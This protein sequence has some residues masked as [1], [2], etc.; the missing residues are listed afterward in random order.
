[1]GYRVS[2]DLFSRRLLCFLFR[3]R[4]HF[5]PSISRVIRSGNPVG[6]SVV[7]YDFDLFFFL[8]SGYFPCALLRFRDCS[9]S[10]LYLLA[11][12][13]ESLFPLWVLISDFTVPL[14]GWDLMHC[15]RCL[16]DDQQRAGVELPSP[17]GTRELLVYVACPAAAPWF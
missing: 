8:F 13:M 4:L 3:E 7:R 2:V 12:K 11:E 15:Y 14:L 6:F 10:F 16:C 17:Y 9:V 1:M 5:P